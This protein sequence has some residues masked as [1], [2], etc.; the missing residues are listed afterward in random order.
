MCVCHRH[1]HRHAVHVSISSYW[2]A[3]YLIVLYDTIRYAMVII[4]IIIIYNLQQ[5]YWCGICFIC[6]WWWWWWWWAQ[7]NYETKQIIYRMRIYI[8]LRICTILI[9]VCVL[10][11]CCGMSVC[12]FV[13]MLCVPA[14]IT[15]AHALSITHP[16]VALPSFPKPNPA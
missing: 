2:C 10:C 11:L 5:I 12:V 1:R 14:H 15:N 3:F 8:V 16:L 7:A 13:W 4:I 9:A 6:C